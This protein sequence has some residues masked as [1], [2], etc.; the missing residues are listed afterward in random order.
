MPVTVLPGAVITGTEEPAGGS[1]RRPLQDGPREPWSCPAQACPAVCTNTSFL[2]SR[3]EEQTAQQPP[4][5]QAQVANGAG[6]SRPAPGGVVEVGVG[7]L[8]GHA[9]CIWPSPPLGAGVASLTEFV[10]HHGKRGPFTAQS[11]RDCVSRRLSAAFVPVLPQ[12]SGVLVTAAARPLTWQPASSGRPSRLGGTRAAG[13][14]AGGVCPALSRRSRFSAPFL[15][16]RAHAPVSSHF[17]LPKMTLQGAGRKPV[18][19]RLLGGPPGPP[20]APRPRA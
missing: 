3:T 20:P 19:T 15:P 5:S 7:S 16:A 11:N 1:R 12:R 2:S 9:C 8:P 17:A 4:K 6:R 14:G 10:S 18:S 13:A